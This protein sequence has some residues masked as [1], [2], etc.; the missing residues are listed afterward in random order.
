MRDWSLGPGDPLALTLAADFR[1]STPD[2]ANDHIWEVEI[3][4]GDPPAL[5]LRTTYGL[6]ARSMR[7]FPRFTIKGKIVTDPAAFPVPPRLRRFYPNFLVFDFAP[8]PGLGVTA[9]YWIPDSH[10]AAGCFTVINRSG[11]PVSLLLE[12]CG[13]LVPLEGQPLAQGIMQSANILSGRTTNLAPVIFLT[14]GPQPGPG[15]YPSL[16][17]DL[18]LAAGGSRTLM[19][20]QAAL[21]KKEH[22][23]E[24]ARRTAARPWEA[25]R[26]RIELVNT[27]Q[28]VEI[29][30]GDVDWDAAIALSQK[31]AFGLLFGPGKYFSNP[32]FVL[33]RQPDQGYS[34]RGD[35]SDHPHLWS[36]QPPL[37]SYYLA[38]LLPGAPQVAR[39][40]VLNFLTTQSEGGAVDWKPGM[41]GQ[42]GRWLATPFLASLAWEYGQRTGDMDFLREAQ[43][44]LEAFVR[45][46]LDER[47]DR[48]HDGFPEWD[49][50]LQTGLEDS[51]A[52]T[53]WQPGGQGG[54][55]SA[56]ES[57]A[58]A[59]LL[60]REMHALAQI[61]EAIGQPEKRG[62]LEL[63]AKK[64]CALAEECWD[65]EAALYHLRDRD[66]HRSPAGKVLGKQRGG[67]TIQPDQSFPQP[68]RLL[69]RIELKGETTR[70]PEV[71]L[72]GMNG[73]TEQIE[74]FARMDFQWGSGLAVATS[75]KLYTSV[76]EVTA[77]GLEKRD[78]LVVSVMDFSH[79]DITLFLPLWAG[80]PSP[81][82][83]QSMVN[84]TL[85]AADR[86]WRPFGVPACVPSLSE[87]D[88]L[89]DP[90]CQ[91]VHL[92]WNQ[93]I[94]EGLLAY[95]LRE[96]AAQLTVRLMSAVIE[97]LKKQ[98][99]FARAY[100][101]ETGSGIGER[102]PVQGLAPLGLFLD[103][104]GVRIESPGR[105]ILSGKNPFPWPVTVKYKGLTV[106]R[107]THRT[108][109]VFPDGQTLTLDDPTDAV[110]TAE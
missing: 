50:P 37:E 46:W 95:G 26:T 104:L 99:A 74:T 75:R 105:V 9:E 67:G 48:D 88:S 55:I 66:T 4:G 94:G 52:F 24:L 108:V 12:L 89:P 96:E 35:G 33:S 103:T 69:V 18:A 6:R 86:F 49:H 70:R 85:F 62:K 29:H 38:S 59:A 60:C 28:T 83:A 90:T 39:D 92:P 71:S 53:V 68:V 101:A 57:P 43:P 8:F 84:R 81:R 45:C 19:W 80:V 87:D 54:E 109:I 77:T 3:G 102:N 79:E 56:A 51:T 32:S 58:L 91:A 22:S 10:T 65:A 31:A 100:H 61:A 72:R 110:V 93:L 27:A 14:G 11:E 107:Q 36:G 98:H 21:S 5:A 15:H 44:A 78:L 64:Q 7:I 82:R 47:R 25:E 23:F 40:L 106:T 73:G 34:P 20:V 17:V 2:Y 76:T 97:N 42:R 63:D 13:Q 30:T 16:T 1:L 41:A